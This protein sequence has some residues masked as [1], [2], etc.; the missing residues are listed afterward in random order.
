MALKL[1]LI[2][3]LLVVFCSVG[4]GCDCPTFWTPWGDNCY[5][6]FGARV[7]WYDAKNHCRTFGGC[8]DLVSIHSQSEQDFVYD[9]WKSLR[10][11]DTTYPKPGMWIGLND[12]EQEGS[13][14]WSD[15]TSLNYRHFD[16]DQETQDGDI[17]FLWDVHNSKWNPKGKWHNHLNTPDWYFQ[18]MCKMSQESGEQL[19]E[20]EKCLA[21]KT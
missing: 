21:N 6:Y 7:S 1:L 9:Y 20:A 18:F 11:E 13:F 14:V 3:N 10:E 17:Y 5:R 16:T 12:I 8:V 15:G 2:V 19:R 4:D